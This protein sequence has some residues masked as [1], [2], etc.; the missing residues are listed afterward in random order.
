M[1]S[2]I[3]EEII[4]ASYRLFKEKGYT[5]TSMRQ[6]ADACGI[7]VGNLSYHFPKKESIIMQIHNDL[8]NFFLENLPANLY[9]HD[10][11]VGYFAAEYSLATGLNF[12]EEIRR[13][14]LDAINH[15]A[16]RNTYYTTHYKLFT[17][18]MDGNYPANPSTMLT[19][20]IAMCSLEFNMLEQF[21]IN[22]G[23]D[24]F[25]ELI[26]KIFMAKVG[27]LGLPPNKYSVE[28]EKGIALGKRL[29]FDAVS[30]TVTF[31]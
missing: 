31:V 28:I 16:L 22:E 9:E 23:V 5:A 6:I 3:K 17:D 14:Y 8:L 25:D 21:D 11:W 7:A 12:T 1:N 26:T 20:T 10:P 15:P 24:A 27:F 2:G 13:I 29:H 4:Q 18:F 19:S 30:Q